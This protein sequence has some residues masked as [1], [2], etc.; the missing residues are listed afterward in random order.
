[1]RTVTMKN[2]KTLQHLKAVEDDDGVVRDKVGNVLDK[3]WVHTAP[4]PGFLG[5]FVAVLVLGLFFYWGA[6]IV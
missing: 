2:I 5:F 4:S 3:F 1:M 6:R